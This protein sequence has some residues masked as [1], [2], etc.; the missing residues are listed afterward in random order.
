MKTDGTWGLD[1][2]P[3]PILE[4]CD[5]PLSD[6]VT[7][8]RGVYYS[9]DSTLDLSSTIGE[10]DWNGW[11]TFATFHSKNTVRFNIIMLPKN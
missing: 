2:Y 1:Y 5:E 4:G 11:V 3:D 8:L 7:D 9:K 10:P 6:G